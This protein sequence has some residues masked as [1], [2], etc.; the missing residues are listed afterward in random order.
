MINNDDF[1]KKIVLELTKYYK[2]DYKIGCII[3]AFIIVLLLSFSFL[4]NI[5][6]YEKLVLYIFCIL[7]VILF[8]YCIVV[9]NIKVVGKL[10]DITSFSTFNEKVIVYKNKF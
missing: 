4:L 2:K 1:N 7:F 5:G 3:L 9:I 10:S 8:I 6:W